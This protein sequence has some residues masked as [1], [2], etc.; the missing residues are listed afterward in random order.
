M[1]IQEI[2]TKHSSRAV[3][4]GGSITGLMV[5][6]VLSAHFADVLVCDRDHLPTQARPRSTV[7]QEHHVHLLLQ[8]GQHILT[9]LFPGLM[10]DLLADGAEVVDLGR[11]VK[12][13]QAGAWK[14]RWTAGLTAHYCTRTLLEH[15]LRARVRAIPN[16]TVLDRIN[17][18]PVFDHGRATGVQ[19]QR[20][21]QSDEPDKTT[22]IAADLVIDASGRGSRIDAILER[23]GFGRV[24]V[25]EI[26]TRLGY[27]SAVFDR[28]KQ[29]DDWKVLL[30][31]PRLPAEKR[32]AVISPIEGHRWMVTAGAW[33]GQEPE[34]TLEGLQSYLKTLPVP[35][36][37]NALQ[38]A[39]AYGPPRRYRMPGG[40]RR[41]FDRLARW[42]DRFLAIGDCVCSINPLFSQG[43]SASAL[44]VEA[45]E[46]VMTRSCTE[47]QRRL[48]GAV[49]RPW[50]QAAAMERQFEDVGPP[51]GLMAGIRQRYFDRLGQRARFDPELAN[52]VLRVNNLV[53]GPE[54]LATPAIMARVLFPRPLLA[55]GRNA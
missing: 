5:A 29:T 12:C 26:V 46:D 7:P 31:L 24:P 36:L 23:A 33:F 9:R 55:G 25:E 13:H 17:A 21:G 35:D 48:C 11:D 53:A 18:A 4:I 2:P 40:K 3:V 8:R 19:V 6:R 38:D 22:C 50:E 14:V 15:R 34:P 30:C 49:E 10:E 37:H 28:P 54:T 41:H 1:K 52:A 27:V 51:S 45:M 44:Q 42:P 39:T 20:V 47:I 32:M 43:M 16:V